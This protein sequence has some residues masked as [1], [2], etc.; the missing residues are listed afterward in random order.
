MS[1]IAFKFLAVSI[2]LLALILFA[3]SFYNLFITLMLPTSVAYV[4]SIIASLIL[5]KW[6][7]TKMVEAIKY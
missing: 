4:L 7:G 5:V 6:L 2:I 1:K 3:D